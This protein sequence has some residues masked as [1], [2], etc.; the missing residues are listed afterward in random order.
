MVIALC[1]SNSPAVFADCPSTDVTGDCEVNFEDFAVMVNQWLDEG[2]MPCSDLRRHHIAAAEAD[3]STANIDA[4][5]G[6]EFMPGTYFIYKT[7]EGRFGK[8]MVENYEPS[9]NHRLTI[10][11]VTYDTNGMPYSYG[12]RLVIR[13]TYSCDL[14]EGRETDTGPDWMWDMQSPATR[15]L[16]PYREAWFK[17]MRRNIAQPD[18]MVWVYIDEPVNIV[19]LWF[20][21]YMSKYETTNAQYCQYL[22]SALDDGLIT[23]YN[24]TVYAF[25]DS[26]HSESYFRTYA[27]NEHSQIAYSAGTFNVRTRDSNDMSN[28]PV[29]MVSW[30]GATA[31]CDYYG[32]KLPTEWQWQAVADYDGTYTYGCGTTIDPNKANYYLGDGN[33][34]NPLGLSSKPYTAPVDHYPSFGYGMNSMTGNVHEWS[35][36]Y[37]YMENMDPWYRVIRGGSYGSAD[38]RCTVSQRGYTS[39]S[40][41]NPD[42]GFRDILKLE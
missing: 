1:L 22:N 2:V 38:Y 16:T 24:D 36:N 41:S 13:G 10:R 25:D 6:N 40:L 32:F 26:S 5:D 23:V 11:W 21:G 9:E 39:A 17:M 18:G 28:H 29:V 34:C 12:T 19:N 31:F 14:D 42:F 8:F 30:Y 15:Y 27:S 4:S 35:R 20:E 33:F 37:F 3:M 7:D